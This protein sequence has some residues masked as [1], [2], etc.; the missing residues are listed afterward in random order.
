MNRNYII[1]ATV[2]VAVLAI[3]MMRSGGEDAGGEETAPATAT[4]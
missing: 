1:T 3:F 2:I 4:E